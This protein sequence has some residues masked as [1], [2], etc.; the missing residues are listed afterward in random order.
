[1][2]KLILFPKAIARVCPGLIIER[3]ILSTQQLRV[4]FDEPHCYSSDV[5][6][7]AMLEGESTLDVSL[8]NVETDKLESIVQLV[9]FGKSYFT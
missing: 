6:C 9:L 5:V 1:M 3:H 2:L 8:H 7:A 4:H